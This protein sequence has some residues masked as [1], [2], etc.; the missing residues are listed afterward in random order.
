MSLERDAFRRSIREALATPEDAPLTERF[1][2]PLV[3]AIVAGAAAGTVEELEVALGEVVAALG[4]VGVPRGRQFVLLASAAAGDTPVEPARLRDALGIL[5]LAHD[6]D[7]ASFVAGRSAA[8]EPVELDDELREAEAIVTV[9][10][11]TAAPG[12]LLGGPFLLCPGAA[13]ARTTAAWHQ[14]R[15]QGGLA[16]ALA[17]ALAVEALAPVDLALTWDATG[18]AAA[19]RGRVRF[20]ALAR[21]ANLD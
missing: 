10:P 20:A 17:F 8:G 15:E 6:P 1:I 19:A 7:G 14:A 16:G 4:V 3:T 11:A 5:V 13:S 18:R 21:D 2:A 12:R 9:G